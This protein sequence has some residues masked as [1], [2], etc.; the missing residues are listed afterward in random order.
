MFGFAAGCSTTEGM[1]LFKNRDYK[2]PTDG[3]DDPW[4]SNV[5]DEV[6][7]RGERRMEESEE[8]RWLRE[9]IMSDRARAIESNLGITD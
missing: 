3:P 5:G 9:T 4:V 1:T 8:P 2:D 7:G 6:E